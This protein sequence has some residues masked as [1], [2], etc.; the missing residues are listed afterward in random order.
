MKLENVTE[1]IQEAQRFLKKARVVEK[2]MKADEK[3]G[4]LRYYGGP[5]AAAMKRAS[6]DL[7]KIL[8]KMRHEI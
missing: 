8:A 5:D 1:A 7:T 3:K 6:L 2:A 4:Y